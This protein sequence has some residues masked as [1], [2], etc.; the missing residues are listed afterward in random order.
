M[1]LR[2]KY[3]WVLSR[4][5]ADCAKGKPM[6][7]QDS[8]G[9]YR[10]AMNLQA[11]A[12]GALSVTRDNELEITSVRQLIILEDAARRI[13][14][15][16]LDDRKVNDTAAWMLERVAIARRWTWVNPLAAVLLGIVAAI[17]GLGAAVLGWADDN[18]VLAVLGAIV[19]SALLAGVVLKYRRENWRI[20][21]EQIA[22]MIIR[23]GL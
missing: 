3:F 13:M 14:S 4:C 17:V 5:H 15:M 19:G 18:I 2:R 6:Y 22:P 20:R 7:E 23:P 12:I 21:A 10:A 16:R 9:R 11:E 8:A 1:L